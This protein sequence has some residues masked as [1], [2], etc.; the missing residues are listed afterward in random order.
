M[1]FR[2]ECWISAVFLKIVSRE[3]GFT[4]KLLGLNEITKEVS[5][6]REENRDKD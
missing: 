3:M 5:K 6:D 1:E 4:S 2:R